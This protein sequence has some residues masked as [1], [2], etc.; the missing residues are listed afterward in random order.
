MSTREKIIIVLAVV[1]LGYGIY[2]LFFEDSGS[3]TSAIQ[4]ETAQVTEAETVAT[5]I[6]SKLQSG[7]LSDSEYFVLAKAREPWV[8][9]PFFTRS[10]S[11]RVS[12][13]QEEQEITFSYTGYV[14]LGTWRYAIINGVEYSVG[15][16][17]DVGGY[18]VRNILPNKV[19]IR[20]RQGDI[21]V[22][23]IEETF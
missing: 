21:T 19:V 11:S 15:E 5:T 17:L 23:F 9:D 22:P 3:D 2:V 1:V 4:P 7:R 20:G 12:E 10:E 14:E 8:R 18:F 6:Q 16:E 13:G